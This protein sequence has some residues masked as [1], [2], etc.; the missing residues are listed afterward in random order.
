MTKTF[1]GVVSHRF[2]YSGLPAMMPSGE[3]IKGSFTGSAGGGL[4]IGIWDLFEI[5]LLVLGIYMIFIKQVTFITSVDYL[6]K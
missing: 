4:V 1:P 3:A 6:F 5:W 2:S